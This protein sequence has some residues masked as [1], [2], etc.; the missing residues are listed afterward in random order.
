MS[1][2][3]CRKQKHR[4]SILQPNDGTCY[5]CSEIHSDYRMKQVQEHHIFYGSANRAVSEAEG[6]KVYLCPSH[7]QYTYDCNPEAIH[8]N[9]HYE[10]SLDMWLKQTAQRKYE[11]TH[12]R[13]DFLRL[14]GKNY[15]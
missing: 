11:A 9:P 3:R 13:E 8:G 10:R 1:G 12:S 14:I 4:K 7:H 15:L 2:K 6:F 5:I